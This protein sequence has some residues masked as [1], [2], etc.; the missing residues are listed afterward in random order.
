MQAP[1]SVIIPCYRCVNTIERAV[2]SVIAQTLLPCELILVEDCSMDNGETLAALYGLQKNM[3]SQTTIKVV[4]LA[5]NCGPGGARNAGWDEATQ[6]Y[7]AFLDADDS[8]HPMKLEI[9]YAWMAARRDVV[10][11]GHP[12][13]LIK[14]DRA[15]PIL[16]NEVNGRVISAYSLL[17][18]NRF[19]ARSVMLRREIAYRFE[20]DKRYAEDYLLWL[21]IVLNGNSAWMLDLPLAYSYKADFGSAGLSRDLWKMECGVRD[22]YKRVYLDRLITRVHYEIILVFSFLKYM[23]RLFLSVLR[24]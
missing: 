8:W 7:L 9:Q 18:G 24:F 20:P 23:R 19:P 11:S 1:V 2:K 12:S 10:M 14:S 17:L 13:I 16:P 3:G 4:A 22:A 15:P 6:P 5:K 21:K